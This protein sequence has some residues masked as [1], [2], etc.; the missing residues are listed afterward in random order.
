MITKNIKIT[1]GACEIDPDTEIDINKEFIIQCP[2]S[3][4]G[5]CKVKDLGE[6][7]EE[8]YNMKICGAIEITDSTTKQK[9]EVKQKLSPSQRMRLA[10]EGRAE[11]RG[12]VDSA[13]IE[14]YYEATMNNLINKLNN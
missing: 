11:R 8:T 2:I 6:D 4:T 12:I 1:N 14:A 3:S 5:I 9:V 10:I 7:T 13:N